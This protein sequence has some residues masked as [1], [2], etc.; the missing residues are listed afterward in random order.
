MNPTRS[1][2]QPGVT[3]VEITDPT[4]ASAGIELLDIDAVQLQS[5]PFRARRVTVRLEASAVLYQ[6]TN[7]RLRTRT[8]VRKGLLAYV[9]SARARAAP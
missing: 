2:D 6:S 4:D 5:I 3:V 7:L 1:I 9:R 8:H